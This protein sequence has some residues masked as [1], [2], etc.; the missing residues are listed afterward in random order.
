[1]LPDWLPLHRLA[2]PVAFAAALAVVV[3]IDRPRGSWGRRLRS[4]FLLGVPWGTLVAVAVVVCVYLFVQRGID[5]PTDPV[6]IPF[7]AWSFFYPEG[8]L[9]SGLSHASLG[10]VVGNLLA[11]LIAGSLAEYAYGHF[12]RRRGGISFRTPLENPFVRAFLVV[13][14]AI[15]A[16]AI[17]SSV[18]AIGPV[19]G[20]SGVVFALWG[21]SLVHYPLGSIVALAGVSLLNLVYEALRDPVVQSAASPSYGGPWW[22]NISIQGHAI[23]FLLGV[24]VGAALLR[25]RRGRSVDPE[26][27][28]DGWPSR[29]ALAVFSGVLLFASSRSLWAVYW[30][31]GNERYVLYRA[32][33][34]GLIVLLALL[35]AL[36]VAGRREPIVPS[37][38]VPNPET[39]RDAV[40]SSSPQSAGLVLLLFGLGMLAGPAIAPNLLAVTDEEL[41]GDPIEVEGYEVTYAENVSN[42][43]VNVVDVE[44]FDRSTRVNTSGVIVKNADRGIWITAVSRGNLQYWGSRSVDVGGT[45]WR[46]TVVATRT[47][48]NAVG[49]G[50]AYRVD[51]EH[52]GERRTAFR[53]EPATAEPIIEGWSVSVAAVDEGFE[54]AV[55][56]GNGTNPSLDVE[57]D[58]FGAGPTAETAPLPG[59]NESVELNGLTLVREDRRIYAESNG[60]R[61]RVLELERHEGRERLRNQ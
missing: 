53:S 16:G 55:R 19:I 38:S 48:W 30:Y 33:G 40:R 44:A 52:D 61:V 26:L 41:P 45:G 9:L 35:V 59:Q 49:G 25:R 11:T 4:R 1:M 42:Q 15:V 39:F 29:S 24:L 21:F 22:A 17:L 18:F 5:D 58:A 47:G 23:G 6:V 10:H 3:A 50:T 57:D 27:G 36:A 7:R 43:M 28:R 20:F 14:V 2:I 46:E 34:I 13:P 54:V 32:V 51:L 31:L 8:M 60:T 56:R 37:W 12:P